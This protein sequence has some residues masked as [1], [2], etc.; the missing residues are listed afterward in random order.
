MECLSSTF[1]SQPCTCLPP[2]DTAAHRSLTPSPPHHTSVRCMLPKTVIV[3][4][5]GARLDSLAEGGESDGLSKAL[6]IGSMVLASS[7]S[8]FTG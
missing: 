8:F 5:I 7:V 1:S 3:V 4:F 6:N 2:S